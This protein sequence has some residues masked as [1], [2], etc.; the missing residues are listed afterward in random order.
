MNELQLKILPLLAKEFKT[1]EQISNQAN[2]PVS[3]IASVLTTLQE[4]K[5]VEVKKE[6]ALVIEETLDATRF[7]KLKKL[8]ERLLIERFL[9][10]KT[11]FTLA[12]LIKQSSQ[13]GPLLQNEIPR[14]VARGVEFGQL[15][16]SKDKNKIITVK[17]SELSPVETAF[18]AFIEGKQLLEEQAKL[19]VKNR[20]A[21]EK[22]V[23][24][25]WAKLTSQGAA[26]L[27]QKG[28]T[29]ISQVTPEIVKCADLNVVEFKQYNVEDETIRINPGKRHPLQLMA[30]E[31]REILIGMGFSEMDGPI[32]ES[33]FRNFDMLF[34][35]QN[36]PAREMM[37]TFFLENPKTC[38]L[39][40]A[41]IE[42]VKKIHEDSYAFPWSAKEASKALLRAHTT[43]TT[44]RYLSKIHLFE[45][46]LKVPCKLFS[47]NKVFRNEAIDR[48]H[49]PEFHQ[50]EGVVAAKGL[51]LSGLMG[52]FSDFYNQLGIN[53]IRF[54]P[55]YNPYTEPS[56]EIFG[57][58]EALEKWVEIGNSGMFRPE[59]L[60]PLEIKHNVYGWGLA[61]ERAA[62]IIFGV[63]DIRKVMGATTNLQWIRNFP[64]SPAAMR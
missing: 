3:T 33:A 24:T 4:A 7:K 62:M 18:N 10:T 16:T 56:M 29:I 34:I 64:A 17:N 13:L 28:K 53:R 26:L 48:T 5:L 58:H 46:N 19:L 40:N 20:L 35:P 23:K 6:A 61:L 55:V 52:I 27:K 12:D 37:D 14:V 44:F 30:D 50:I 38:K 22:E 41:L 11:Q 9:T 36:H 42:K 51:T 54:K 32:V 2:L 21:V 60:E 8:P 31:M 25:T 45:K 47:I 15:E 63:D 43:P 57:F 1:L 59:T 39:P 49:L